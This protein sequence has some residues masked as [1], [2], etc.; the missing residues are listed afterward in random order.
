MS[1]SFEI[2]SAQLSLVALLL[3][4]GDLDAVCNDLLKQF[5]PEGESP[6]FF[7]HDAL[8]LDF[9]H[10][11][12]DES[13]PKLSS[14]LDS[15]R[16]CRLVPVAVRSP[17][18]VWLEASKVL[19]LVEAPAEAKPKAARMAMLFSRTNMLLSLPMLAAMAMRQT[20]WG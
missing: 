5:G 3:K 6:D 9:S 18:P 20:M 10:L 2:K 11:E 1:V 16:E 7:D 12:T 14:L 4:T 15:V 8:V 17:H 19:G 13:V